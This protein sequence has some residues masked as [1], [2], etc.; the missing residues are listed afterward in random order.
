MHSRPNLLFLDMQGKTV[1]STKTILQR[2]LRV[3]YTIETITD[4][5]I[6]AL[7]DASVKHYHHQIVI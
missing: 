6:K 7:G 1:G 4:H 3:D 5:T 2:P